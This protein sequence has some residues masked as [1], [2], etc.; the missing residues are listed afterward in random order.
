MHKMSYLITDVLPG[1]KGPQEDWV[2]LGERWFR[3][4][5]KDEEK[6]ALEVIGA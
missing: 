5:T 6:K 4:L 3:P 1:E 2:A